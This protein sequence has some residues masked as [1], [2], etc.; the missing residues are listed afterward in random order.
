MPT[1]KNETARKITHP[2]MG[3]MEWKPGETKRLPFFVP[4]EELGLTM[5]DDAPK[6]NKETSIVGDWE[7]DIAAGGAE[8]L[9]L[10]YIEAF[11]LSVHSLDGA[12]VMQIGDSDEGDVLIGAD[13]S[14]WSSYSYARCPYLTFESVDGAIVRVK[15]E[16]RNT[17]N[18]LRRGRI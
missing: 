9:K 12:A 5:T 1:Y 8:V 6:V 18:T 14:H 7:I 3:Y 13:E 16:E 15:Q 2:D 4:H 11:E 17:R 10:P